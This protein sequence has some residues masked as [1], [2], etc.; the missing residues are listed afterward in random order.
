MSD[1]FD[2]EG[3]AELSKKL[4]AMG[5]VTGSKILRSSL[6]AAATPVVKSARANVPKG[7]KA[8][9]THKGRIVAPG[10]A[11]RNLA[12]RSRLSKDKRTATVL[13]GVKREA[14]YAISFMEL[15]TKYVQKRPWLTKALEAEK[16]TVVKR[17]ADRMRDKILKEARK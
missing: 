7:S 14:Y 13:I 17:F 16:E 10:F 11:S 4:S 8:H 1:S 5:S 2:V 9:T 6:M 3:I 12:K 15:G